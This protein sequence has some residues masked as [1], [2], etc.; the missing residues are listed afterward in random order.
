MR[1]EPDISIARDSLGLQLN[2]RTPK[3]LWDVI[4][5]KSG[6]RSQSSGFRHLRAFYVRQ[7]KL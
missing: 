4:K 3:L 1:L 6:M 7:L 5:G 2:A